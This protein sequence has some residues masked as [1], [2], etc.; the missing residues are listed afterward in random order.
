MIEIVFYLNHHIF[1]KTFT[2]RVRVFLYQGL[3]LNSSLCVQSAVIN[4]FLLSSPLKSSH[5]RR[6]RRNSTCGNTR[7]GLFSLAS[8]QLPLVTWPVSW[9][10]WDTVT[11]HR[12]KSQP[13]QDPDVMEWPPLRRLAGL[14]ICVCRRWLLLNFSFSSFNFLSFY[15]PFSNG[16]LVTPVFCFMYIHLMAPIE[17]VKGTRCEV[18]WNVSCHATMAMFGWRC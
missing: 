14:A 18:M 6:H 1:E 5:T 9:S 2:R 8:G 4:L 3:F 12:P 10:F 15:I 13:F 11:T 7:A 17:R 16:L